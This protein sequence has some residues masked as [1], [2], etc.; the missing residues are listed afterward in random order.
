MKNK[1]FII[2]TI[3]FV[4][5][6]NSLSAIILPSRF[7]VTESETEFDIIYYV[8]ED[9]KEVPPLKNNDVNITQSFAIEKNGV[10]GEVRYSLFTDC[11]GDEKSLKVQYAM[12][13]FMCVNNAAGYEVPP[14][15]I[16]NFNDADVKN[17]FNGDFG[18]TVFLQDAVTEFGD[19]YKYMVIEFFYKKDQGLVMR[20]FMFNEV[21]FTGMNQ[22]G[23]IAAD[24]PLF[25]NY[26]TFKFMEKNEAGEFVSEE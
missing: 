5:L 1:R 14:D 11:G 23:S 17:E 22:D 25:T 19:G 9:M 7:K 2:T 6:C 13:V 18:C 21:E 8:T 15:A 12:W 3:I 10:T 4:L 16:S 20:T 26:H 24:S